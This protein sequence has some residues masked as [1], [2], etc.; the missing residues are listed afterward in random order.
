MSFLDYANQPT[1]TVSLTDALSPEYNYA[2]SQIDMA[3]NVLDNNTVTDD[4]LNPKP[5]NLDR[6]ILD[7]IDSV[8]LE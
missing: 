1:E 2:L 4:I 7:L 3:R 5:S 8:P 6:Q